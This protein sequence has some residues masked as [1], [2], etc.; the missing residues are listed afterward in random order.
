MTV[1]RIVPSELSEDDRWR[2]NGEYVSADAY[3][4]AIHTIDEIFCVL[5][6]KQDEL[7]ADVW[8][9]VKQ[10]TSPYMGAT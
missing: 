4:A 1:E 10:L 8:E 2:K 9:R 5:C 7:P 6:E 3:D